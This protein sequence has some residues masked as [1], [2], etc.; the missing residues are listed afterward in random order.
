[1][2][3]FYGNRCLLVTVYPKVGYASNRGKP[4]KVFNHIKR[5]YMTSKKVICYKFRI[6]PI[7]DDN[8]FGFRYTMGLQNGEVAEWSKAH[9]WKVCI[10]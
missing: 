3:L 10:R 9:A 7:K 4:C 8:C 5:Q 6:K 2:L 1:M